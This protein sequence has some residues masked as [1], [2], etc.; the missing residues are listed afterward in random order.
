[1]RAIAKNII[2]GL[3]LMYLFFN[4]TLG[5]W[6]MQLL[7][8]KTPSITVDQL[9]MA[10]WTTI[11]IGVMLFIAM[12]V[13]WLYKWPSTV[14]WFHIAQG[15]I[16]LGGA[17]SASWILLLMYYRESYGILSGSGAIIYT[18]GVFCM[19]LW[20]VNPKQQP[21]PTPKPKKKVRR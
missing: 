15:L 8:K 21:E 4:A 2:V 18:V 10:I 12:M 7:Q 16:G 11:T 9:E 20:V 19:M 14:S 6:V 13:A 3:F 5:V 17:I 1:M